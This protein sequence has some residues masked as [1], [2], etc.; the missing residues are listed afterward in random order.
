MALAQ[1]IAD[2]PSFV[3]GNHTEHHY[4]LTTLSMADALAE[5]DDTSAELAHV[6]EPRAYLRFPYGAANCALVDAAHAR[7]YRVVGWHVDS[8]DWC[9][10]AG[11][12]VCTQQMFQWVPDAY[13]KRGQA[14]AQSGQPD[15]A[16]EMWET[17][18][19]LYPESDAA[20]LASQDL[21]RINRT[22][23]PAK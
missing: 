4:N 11:G 9:Y 23:P 5:I 10:A 14:Y 22:A 2:D 1:Q 19:K 21:Q 8:A 13:R 6:A 7:G 18:I 15:K 16:R 12:G 20:R 17:V 3:L